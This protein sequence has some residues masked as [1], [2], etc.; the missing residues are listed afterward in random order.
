M[1]SWEDRVLTV[2]TS[3]KVKKIEVR[4][5]VEDCSGEVW[6]TDIMLQG[7]TLATIWTGH[8]SE[9]KWSFDQ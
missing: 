6:F 7:G 4:L 8:T 9:I 2:S 5:V 1:L 3:N